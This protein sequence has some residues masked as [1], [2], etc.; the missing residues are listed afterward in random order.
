MT[1]S[2]LHNSTVEII[3][4]DVTDYEA[5]SASHA[6]WAADVFKMTNERKIKKDDDGH[7]VKTVESD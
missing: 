2:A 4:S 6:A 5:K 1:S 7:N 3:R